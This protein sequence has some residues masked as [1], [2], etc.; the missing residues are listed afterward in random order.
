LC[1]FSLKRKNSCRAVGHIFLFVLP[2]PRECMHISLFL[3]APCLI[4][5]IQL[6]AN[7]FLPPGNT[8]REVIFSRCKKNAARRETMKD[9]YHHVA[10]RVVFLT[11]YKCGIKLGT[12]HIRF[13]A[14]TWERMKSK[15]ALNFHNS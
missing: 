8:E 13:L 11:F 3:R 1:S 15:V 12:R 6:G 4:N 5:L 9:F 14:R 10:F 7:C 2:P